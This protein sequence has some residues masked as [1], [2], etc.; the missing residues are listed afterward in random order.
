[1]CEDKGVETVVF[2]P[3]YLSPPAGFS[4]YR[5]VF[6]RYRLLEADPQPDPGVAAQV[7]RRRIPRGAHLVAFSEAT[8]AAVALAPEVEA[9]SLVLFSPFFRADAALVARVKALSVAHRLG[10]A[11][12]FAEAAAP[13][14]FGSLLL[15]R[16][17]A[18]IAAWAEGLGE[19]DLAAW[20]AAVGGL[21][22]RRRDL[23][24]LTAPVLVAVGTED[25]FTPMR[26]GHEV[27]EWV[28]EQRGMLVTVEGAGHFAP[29]ENLAEASRLAHG[30]VERYR[31]FLEGPAEWQ[32]EEE[33]SPVPLRFDPEAPS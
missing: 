5:E 27:T 19:R 32:D 18:Q 14:F 21:G 2:L 22:D 3:G 15:D 7:W 1:L 25:V 4:A 9:S 8:I 16:G 6:S 26:Y 13:W 31:E 17:Q 28:P 12:A 29:W 30:F 10:G 23:R 24:K 11:D 33:A 20:L